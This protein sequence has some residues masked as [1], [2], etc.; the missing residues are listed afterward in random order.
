MQR[1]SLVMLLTTTIALAISCVLVLEIV[2]IEAPGVLRPILIY[3]AIITPLVCQIFPTT[4]ARMA[5]VPTLGLFAIALLDGIEHHALALDV[6]LHAMLLAILLAAYAMLVDRVASWE[7]DLARALSFVSRSDLAVVD[8]IERERL[9]R[10]EGIVVLCHRLNQPLS[11][12]HLNWTRQDCAERESQ[13]W[14]FASQFERL[15]MRESVLQQ[16][17]ATI[18]DSDIVLSDGTQ[19]GLFVICPATFER[20][21]EQLGGRLETMLQREFA[22]RV[23]RSVVTSDNHGFVLADLMIAARGSSAPAP[24]VEY[25]AVVSLR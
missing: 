19:N 24:S 5:W 7:H 17:G 14:S 16:V 8:A 21:A 25:G 20:G 2:T 1:K 3:A 11:V 22:A 10:C 13:D 4:V 15:S 18:R 9:K 12:L 6:W 23:K